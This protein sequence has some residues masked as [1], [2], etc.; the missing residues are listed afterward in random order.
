[1]LCE[2]IA[3]EGEPTSTRLRTSLG[4]FPGR[5]QH[6]PTVETK[7]AGGRPSVLLSDG[8]ALLPSTGQR[9]AVGTSRCPARSRRRWP[10]VASPPLLYRRRV[11]REGGRCL[12]APSGRTPPVW[13]GGRAPARVSRPPRFHE[14]RGATWLILPVVICLS[15]SLSHA[16]LSSHPTRTGKPRMAH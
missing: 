15:Q 16:C 7:A 3:Q 2:S 13:P 6:L 4:V 10:A 11:S 12:S 9:L 14:R 1:M 5:P 8:R